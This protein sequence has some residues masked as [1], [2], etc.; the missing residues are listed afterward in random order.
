MSAAW[1]PRPVRRIAMI[2]SG[3]MGTQIGALA[4][5][6]GYEVAF[7]DMM[8]AAIERAFT[9]AEQEFLPAIV[10]SG[11]LGERTPTV[12]DARARMR[13]ATSLED[14]VAGVDMVIEAVREE[15]ETKRTVFA[16]LSRLAPDA[17]LATNSSSFPSR[18]VADVVENPGRLL[19]MHFF[20]PI[21]LRTMLELMTCGAT[22]D[23]VFAAAREVGETMGLFVAQVQ[24]ESHGFIIN[25]IWR[26]IKRESLRVVDEGHATPE[27]VDEM[28]LRFFFGAQRAPFETMDMVGLDVIADIEATYHAIG[29]DPTDT[30]I[31]VLIA[32][33]KAGK[34]GEK[35]GEGFYTHPRTR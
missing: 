5:A 23:P 32:K 26:A 10:A 9:R 25:R 31:P 17:I 4:A 24:G 21:W 35:T 15:I 13:A 20:A 22:E 34:L 1:T 8:P 28:F 27:E 19:N 7:Y 3:L 30:P 6:A 11:M 18:R 33:V 2:G 16:E 14:S 29:K 12:A